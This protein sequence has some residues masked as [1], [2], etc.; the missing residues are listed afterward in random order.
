MSEP[1]HSHESEHAPHIHPHEEEEGH[2][3][4]H[5][6]Q[7]AGSHGHGHSHAAITPLSDPALATRA[8]IL[9]VKVSLVVL[10]VTALFQL[11]VALRSG[12]VALLAD[13]IHNFADA[14]T[15]IPLWLAFS[16]SQ[17]LRNARYTYGYG[18][19][20]DLA[21][22]AIVALIFFSALEVYSQSIQKMLHPVVVTNL[23]WVAAAAG[24]GFLGN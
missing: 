2:S 24:I 7:P 13:T 8:G 18:R 15:A 4:P 21:G 3:H 9:A 16:L 22:A 1:L 14:L 23:G 6:G 12:S 19:A 20:E 5:P 17:R 10:L 11:G